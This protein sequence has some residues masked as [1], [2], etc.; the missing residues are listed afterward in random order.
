MKTVHW[1]EYLEKEEV[2]NNAI[3]LFYLFIGF[4]IGFIVGIIL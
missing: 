4:S 3:N 2:S 1:L